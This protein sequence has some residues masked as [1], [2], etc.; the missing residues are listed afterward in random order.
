M[1][2]IHG[3][4]VAEVVILLSYLLLWMYGSV[5]VTVLSFLSATLY[6]LCPERRRRNKRGGSGVARTLS[7]PSVC[8]ITQLSKVSSSGPV[9]SKVGRQNEG[10]VQTWTGGFVILLVAGFL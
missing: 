8:D 6:K 2:V 10:E 7:L 3:I 1:H 5:S 4:T 9:K